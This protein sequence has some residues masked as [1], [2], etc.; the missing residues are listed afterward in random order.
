[1][2]IFLTKSQG[3]IAICRYFEK[4]FQGHITIGR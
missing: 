1:M 3:H 2:I 4:S